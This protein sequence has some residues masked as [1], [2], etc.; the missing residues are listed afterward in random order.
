MLQRRTGSPAN[1]VLRLLALLLTLAL[2]A[3]ACG[4]DDDD[5]E[6]GD[7][8]ENTEG[9][10]AADP[11]TDDEGEPVMGGEIAY[12]LEAETN[13]G[14]CLQEAQL[15]PPG[16]QIARSL[17]DTLTT[18]NE[19]GEIE[20]YLAESVEPNEDFTEWTITP[21]EGVTFHDGTAL[22]AQ[23]IAD[24][25]NE[26]RGAG[27][28]RS[29]PLYPFVFQDI[30]NVE[31]TPE[32][33]VVITTKRPWAALPWFLW[34]SGRLGIMGRAQLE[35]DGTGCANNV[36]GTGPF[37]LESWTVNQEL[38]A[39]R[40]D[41]YWQ[42]DDAGNQLPYLDKVTYVPIP[43]VAQRVN[44]LESGQIQAMHTSDT[45]QISDR[46]RPMQEAGDI[47]L[48]ESDK[49]GEVNYTM[50]NSSVPPFDN[51]DARLAVAYAMDTQ[52]LIDTR[53]G[54]IGQLA[55]GPFAEGV[56]GYLEDSG[57]VAFDPEKAAEHA[58]AYEETVGEPLSFV[59]T[60]VTSESGTLT[61]QEIQTQMRDAGIEMEL[62]PAGDQATTINAALAGD[63][64]AVGWRNHP[65]ADPD[66]QY[67]WWYEGSPVNFGRI[68]DPE[69]NRLLDEGR[70]ADP[71]DRP[72]IYE[73]LNRR[74]A[75]EAYNI[76]GSWAVWSVS[77]STD[78]NGLL[79]PT[80]PRGGNFPGLGT[81]HFM[82]GVWLSE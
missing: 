31:A 23:I 71:A 74:F 49:F 28:F 27:T 52:F 54:G 59:Y 10:G 29:P 19:E 44:A 37:T 33:T 68:A 63:F 64:Q 47:K 32:G 3:A 50:L 36:I 20:P 13:G 8:G 70:E 12:G 38:V 51:K 57:W 69:I 21:R 40:N 22:D 18:P 9:E 25:L 75:S 24:N 66:T 48:L 39:A 72:A 58:A 6:S 4:G 14:F 78:V 16:I 30:E 43:E 65:G 81:G 55:S 77:T 7:G 42:T 46:L 11:Q 5:P 76:W 62:R 79:G 53:G 60:Y 45:E 73:E 15:A 41:S 82:H 56:M 67:N 26:Y 61:A 2:V 1:A 80:L 34:S 35:A 17:Y